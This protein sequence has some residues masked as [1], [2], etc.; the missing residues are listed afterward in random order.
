MGDRESLNK[1]RRRSGQAW[2]APEEVGAREQRSTPTRRGRSTIT[3][4]SRWSDAR[5]GLRAP[6]RAG[7]ALLPTSRVRSKGPD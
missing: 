6:Q 2:Y 5:P 7:I 1:A 4:R 3:V